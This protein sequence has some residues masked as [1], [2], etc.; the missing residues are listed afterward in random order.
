[1]TEHQYYNQIAEDEKLTAIWEDCLEEC[2]D[3]YDMA[4]A[5]F[6]DRLDERL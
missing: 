3:D 6:N 5:M 4:Y 2:D 1:M